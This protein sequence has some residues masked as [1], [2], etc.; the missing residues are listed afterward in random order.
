VFDFLVS[1]LRGAGEILGFTVPH[2]LVRSI[3]GRRL[4]IDFLA[5]GGIVGG[6]S[7]NSL[8]PPK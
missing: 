6:C 8:A 3:F 2:H 4:L 1:A 5:M 7:A